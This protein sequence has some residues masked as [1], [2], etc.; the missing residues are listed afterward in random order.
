M[1]PVPDN[2]LDLLMLQGGNP[3]AGWSDQQILFEDDVA[4]VKDAAL[5]KMANEIR[6]REA[7]KAKP[8]P[9]IPP[10]SLIDALGIKK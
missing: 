3:Y 1:Q 10:Q 7:Y 4:P 8:R 2:A 9:P 5:R 6:L